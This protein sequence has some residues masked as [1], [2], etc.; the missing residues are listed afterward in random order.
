[1]HLT[2]QPFFSTF[3]QISRYII[4]DVICLY[5]FSGHGETVVPE[6]QNLSIENLVEDM[7][8][9]IEQLLTLHKSILGNPNIILVGHSLGG[10]IATWI[11]APASRI[12]SVIQALIVVDVVEGSAIASLSHM[13]NVLQSRPTGFETLKDAILWR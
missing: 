5:I 6:E 8:G 4:V 9:C 3:Y 11:A 10:A 2:C 7:T 1:M 12:S 13:N